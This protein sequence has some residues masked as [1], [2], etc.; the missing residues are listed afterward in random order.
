MSRKKFDATGFVDF[1]N[2]G[3][4]KFEQAQDSVKTN[5]SKGAVTVRER[6]KHLGDP[7]VNQAI[8]DRHLA[9][10][11]RVLGIKLNKK[12]D[13]DEV[14]DELVKEGKMTKSEQEQCTKAFEDVYFHRQAPDLN[15]I[16]ETWGKY[17][18]LRKPLT[19]IKQMLGLK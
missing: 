18:N 8:H 10:G 1:D 13:A 15:I 9:A 5:F 14:M 16:D 7:S 4:S 17:P 12:S 3:V 6:L 2:A 19:Q 11:W